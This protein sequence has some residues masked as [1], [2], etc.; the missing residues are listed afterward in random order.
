MSLSCYEVVAGSFASVFAIGFAEGWLP[1]EQAALL[2]EPQCVHFSSFSVWM[3]ATANGDICEGRSHTPSWA[4]D[5][6]R[7]CWTLPGCAHLRPL[8]SDQH[9]FHPHVGASI[10]SFQQ[11]PESNVYQ[12]LSIQHMPRAV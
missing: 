12:S 11:G 2:L 10:A 7:K 9:A 6:L 5:A 8:A 1:P 3:W 4:H